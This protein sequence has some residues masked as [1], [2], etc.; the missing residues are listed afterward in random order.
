MFPPLNDKNL[1]IKNY[2]VSTPIDG[3]HRS[4]KMKNLRTPIKNQLPPF[5][6]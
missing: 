3:S 6:I 2:Y 4:I 5:I 1:M